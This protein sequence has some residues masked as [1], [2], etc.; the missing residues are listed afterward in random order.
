MSEG[1]LRPDI[2]LLVRMYEFLREEIL[3]SISWQHRLMMGEATIISALLAMGLTIA[4]W[5]TLLIAI[6]PAVLVLSSAW[7]VEQ[8]RMMR[9]GDFLQLLEHRINSEVGEPVMVWENWLR[10]P[11]VSWH[12]PHRIHHVAQYVAV[13]GVFYSL[14]FFSLFILW[15]YKLIPDPACSIFCSFFSFLLL[16]L[17]I[18]TL[19]IISH[20]R[21]YPIDD[22]ADFCRKYDKELKKFIEKVGYVGWQDE[23]GSD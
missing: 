9:A 12:D 17:L 16:F 23:G 10:R 14:G 6:P 19:R 15:F 2:L 20:K 21:R 7:M 1:S 18:L 4:Q 13:I 11:G 5:E 22:F 8:T 3:N